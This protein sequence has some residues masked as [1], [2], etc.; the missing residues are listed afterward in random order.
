MSETGMGGF[1]KICFLRF[2]M[3]S[4]TF[5]QLKPRWLI[6][7]SALVPF[8]WQVLALFCERAGY[9]WSKPPALKPVLAKTIFRCQKSHQ[10]LLS[11]SQVPLISQHLTSHL[12]VEQRTW[13]NK[14]FV[15]KEHLVCIFAI[16]FPILNDSS[17]LRM[18]HV[19]W[20]AAIVDKV[21]H[22]AKERERTVM[23]NSHGL[24][25]AVTV[26]LPGLGSLG[27]VPGS[28]TR[29][30]FARAQP[31]VRAGPWDATWGGSLSSATCKPNQLHFSS[32]QMEIGMVNLYD[33]VVTTQSH[34]D[35]RCHKSHY[36][37]LFQR[38]LQTQC[39]AKGTQF[40]VC[41]W[42]NYNQTH[43]DCT[44]VKL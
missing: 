9:Y 34:E 40:C 11:I 20:P 10:L 17:F 43:A 1:Y 29:L 23:T 16:Y 41:K 12:S 35:D 4:V 26:W 18:K 44:F 5:K 25:Q 14:S 24:A 42:G 39:K 7:A 3:H 36:R 31:G 30:V 6:K 32:Q 28:C 2:W 22:H 15:A 27:Q 33:I 8:W 13:E 21:Q 37:V 19:M 38:W